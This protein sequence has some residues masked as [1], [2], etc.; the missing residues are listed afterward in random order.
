MKITYLVIIATL[1]C[2]MTIFA[3]DTIVNPVSASDRALIVQE[4]TTQ[5]ELEVNQKTDILQKEIDS[6]KSELSQ[7]S[8]MN[9]QSRRNMDSISLSQSEL[10]S[11]LSDLSVQYENLKNQT[12]TNINGL[13]LENQELENVT[14]NLSLDLSNAKND[15]SS[16]TESSERNSESIASVNSALGENQRNAMIAVLVVLA[17]VLITYILLNRKQNNTNK[18]LLA[19]Q[20][21]IFEQQVSD[22]QKLA[23]WLSNQAN[24][25]FSAQGGN[26][27][28]DHSF[29]KRVADEIIRI[30]TNLTRMDSSIKGFKQLSASVKKLEQSL[31]SNGY[32]I[33]D[34]LDKPYN[35]GMNVQ[36]NFVID[37]SMSSGEQRIT[38]IIKPQINFHGKLIQAAQVEVSQ[39]E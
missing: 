27:E 13:Q 17:I 26:A 32:E 28:P 11:M 4:L 34:L 23:D 24:E 39:G 21:K 19:E 16:L 29:A 38:R 20:N 12:L 6:L 5:V 14:S 8:A 33:E 9:E 2:N 35:S 3:Q 37:E 1:F 10:K 18:T 25:G 22:S 7:L 36:A 30:T 15:V 31:N